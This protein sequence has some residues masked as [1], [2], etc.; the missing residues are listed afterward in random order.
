MKKTL[1]ALIFN[2]LLC[3]LAAGGDHWPQ[4]RGPSLDG[5]SDSK[6]L[7]EKWSEQENVKWKVKLPSW[8][9]S[10]PA[11]WGD[12]IFV[13]SAS[14]FIQGAEA[15]NV[16][17]MGGSRKVEGL[18]LLLLC[19]SKADGKELWR[20]TLKGAN[21]QIGKQNMST[22]SPVTDGAMVWWLTGT[23]VL[24]ALT[25]EGKEAW[26]VDLQKTY[27]KFGLNWGYGSSPLLYESM[28]VVPVLHG[29]T[30][31]EPSYIVAFDGKTG[32][33]VWRV[34][35]P[36]D[37]PNESPDAYTTVMPMKVGASM[38]L[39][40][41]GGDYF[42]GH[43][44]KTGK[45]L[46]RCGGLNP[47]EKDPKKPDAPAAPNPWFRMVCSPA[48]VDDLVFGCIKKKVTVVC[49]AGGE[50][51]VT[52][53]HTAWT[54]KDITYD[55]P[56]PVSDGKYMYILNDG[57]MMTCVD[58]KTGKA[59]YD[60]QRLPRGTYSASPLLADGKIYVTSEGARTTVLAAGP[61]F[62]VLA[63]NQVDDPYTL[64]SIA[65]SGS[66]LFLRTSSHLY[67]ISKK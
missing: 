25:V 45:E 66:E 44:P 38:Q 59:L 62:K 10:T 29:M 40:V 37:A 34:E 7:P 13:P 53:T 17:G 33:A 27:G 35:R 15:K 65:V 12:R 21:Y 31:D 67:C 30:T 52:A 1:A 11:I 49:R 47:A 51:L 6:N 63:E 19:L 43:D 4:W 39:I 56:T 9:G 46:W 54:S 18:D 41:G 24:T 16:K 22:P 5:T 8:S 60:K 50:G 26:Q 14:E 36:T 64:S 32:K 55:V 20:S 3:G 58:P 42:T 48:I 57:G 2:G 28:V 23:G 61:E